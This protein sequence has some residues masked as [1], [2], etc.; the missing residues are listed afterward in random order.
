MQIDSK[1][2]YIK[3]VI[4]ELGS[5]Y[6]STKYK[7]G[8]RTTSVDIESNNK[9]FLKT[10]REVVFCCIT[11][12]ALYHTKTTLL[13]I[14]HFNSVSTFIL[15][16]PQDFE[17]QQKRKYYRVKTDNE[18]KLYYDEN[19]TQKVIPCRACNLSAGGIRIILQERPVLPVFANL[20]IIFKDK[21]ITAKGKLIRCYYNNNIPQAA[22]EFIEI[23]K[24]DIEYISNFMS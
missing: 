9:I 22:F 23:S 3:I 5:E 14:Q 16:T 13:N 1:I 20:D 11:E 4:P 15:M 8:G 10:P 21:T 2:E 18:V 17:E 12:K 24:E 6:I 19:G 7:T